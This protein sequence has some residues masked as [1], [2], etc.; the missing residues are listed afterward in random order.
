MRRTCTFAAMLLIS[1]CASH[2]AVPTCP[3]IVPYTAEQQNQALDELCQLV[4]L[5]SNCDPVEYKK[6]P[7]PTLD[8][9]MQDYG[10]LRAA[11]RT[12]Q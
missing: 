3:A 6:R 1:G 10:E 8:R 12:C 2:V 7:R 4:G 5:N 9:F 11:L